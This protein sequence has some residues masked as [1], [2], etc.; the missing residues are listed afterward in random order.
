[1]NAAPEDMADC[2]AD[3]GITPAALTKMEDL[4]KAL[5]KLSVDEKAT[6]LSTEEAHALLESHGCSFL[7]FTV[8]ANVVRAKAATLVHSIQENFSTLRMILDR[9]EATIHKR[10]QKKSNKSRLGVILAAWDSNMAEHHRPDFE[11]LEAE[12]ISER[13]EIQKEHRDAL[14]W[15]YINQE[16]LIKPRILPLFMSSRG[17]CH[18]SEF[19]I[20]DY[21]A[22]RIGMRICAFDYK[23]LPNHRMDLTTADGG[24]HYGQLWDRQDHPDKYARLASQ[25]FS[26]PARGS[27]VLEAQERVLSFL[28]RCAKLVMHEYAMDTNAIVRCPSQPPPLPSSGKDTGFA[29][30]ETV[31]AEAPYKKPAELNFSKIAT[32]LAA[33]RDDAADHLWSLR[34][35]PSY[36]EAHALEGKEHRPENIW[37]EGIDKVANSFWSQE[38]ADQ[39]TRAYCEFEAYTELEAQANCLRDMQSLYQDVIKP[40]SDLPGPY[41]DAILRF[42]FHILRACLTPIEVLRS[43]YHMSPAMRPYFMYGLSGEI[44]SIELMLNPRRRLNA[45]QERIVWL[46]RTLC[47]RDHTLKAIGLTNVVDELQRL[48]NSEHKSNST[49]SSYIASYVSDLAI[50]CEC[51]RQME[52]YQ[53]WA[54]THNALMKERHESLETDWLQQYKP[55]MDMLD[56]VRSYDTLGDLGRPEGERY[57][58]PVGKRRTQQNVE[59]MRQAEKN[60]DAF[61][62]KVDELTKLAASSSGT[63]VHALLTQGR[64]LQ[65]TPEWVEP[66]RDTQV[67]AVELYVPFSR[68]FF[69]NEKDV[70]QA[71]PEASPQ[72][73]KVKQKTRGTKMY[74]VEIDAKEPQPPAATELQPEFALN[75]R[76]LKVFR[77][78]FHSPSVT[79]T[80][81][82]IAWTDFLYAMVSVGFIPEKLYGSVWQFSPDPDKLAVERSIQFH[83]P[84]GANTKILYRIARRHGRR[85]NRA[86]GWDGSFFTSEEN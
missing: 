82:E 85:L 84:H 2:A 32:L 48:I 1:M 18:P 4:A 8:T 17:R 67:S 33:K 47:E 52:I 64:T 6:D 12:G 63:A 34:E 70:A 74:E 28:V 77:T 41:T 75:A 86:Y 62:C 10:W 58:Y 45:H 49:I 59:A 13:E 19:A 38:L 71:T 11:A 36:F 20:V 7:N 16:D 21:E 26:D 65:R 78:L 43:G 29:S 31:A 79:A 57:A 53:P 39:I 51:L 40:D 50:L 23:I 80:P 56:G 66:K 61:W 14:L 35:D 3:V 83:E 81:G 73:P 69:D 42:R 15:P 27:L 44:D 54:H 30:L 37:P 25:K 46:L 22:C 24:R 68:R 76:A 5:I 55:L 60:L 72:E 9:H